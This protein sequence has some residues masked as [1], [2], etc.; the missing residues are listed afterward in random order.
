MCRIFGYIGEQ[1]VKQDTL[2]LVSQLQIHGGPDSQNFIQRR[3]WSLGNNRLA[4]QGIAGGLQPYTL[5]NKIYVVFNGE[6]YNHNELR[7]SL[8]RRGYSFKDTCDGSILPSLYQEYGTDFVKLLDGMFAVAIIDT[9]EN[10]KLILANDPV[11][12]KSLYYQWD[13]RTKTLKF[14][15]EIP[16]LLAFEG[17]TKELRLNAIDDYLTAKAVLGSETIYKGIFSLPPSS[18][19]IAN[20]L[21]Q[22]KLKNYVS[23]LN[24]KIPYTNIN[25]AGAYLNEVIKNEVSALMLADVPACVVTSG[26]LDSSYITALASKFSDNLHS[27]NIWYEGS[28]P[29]DER[30]YAKEVS[31]IYKTTHHQILIKEKDFTDI[32]YR[33]LKHMGQPNSAPHCLSTYALFEAVKQAGFKVA[34]A[35]EGADEFFGG[36]ARFENATVDVKE[37]WLPMYLDKLSAVSKSQRDALYSPDYV[38]Y[39]RNEATLY[40]KS[41]DKIETGERN[42]KSRLTALLEFDQ[43]HRFPYYILRR[44]DHLSMAHSVEVR[45]PFCQPRIMA[46]SKKMP[47]EFKIFKNQGKHILYKAA[48]NKLPESIMNRPKQPFLLPIASML[49]NGHVIHDLLLDTI[50][51]REF[52]SRNFFKKNEVNKLIRKQINSPSDKHAEA[53]W[54]LMIMELWLQQTGASLHI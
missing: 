49:K 9:R 50:N 42:H 5:D 20:F 16:A 11:G 21:V 37:T 40:K 31:R 39:L 41:F 15:S 27:F 17:I 52:Q 14:S 2:R 32:I 29:N 35:G 23:L 12:I 19:L 6:I 28:W 46:L 47:D 8:K 33:M 26:G 48:K 51:S 53:L 45:V 25:E 38:E 13:D 7:V 34:L 54:A 1:E 22:P 10:L 44:V 4:I 30:H 43:I 36:Y 3:H 18:I 24:E